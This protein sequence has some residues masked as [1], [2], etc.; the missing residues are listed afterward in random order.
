VNN[1]VVH[2]KLTSYINSTSIEKKR[3][4]FLVFKVLKNKK[5]ELSND[6]DPQMELVGT[7]LITVASKI[8]CTLV[9]PGNF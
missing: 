3:I 6:I 5:P 1:S 7:K 2:L 4:D 9:S 8:C